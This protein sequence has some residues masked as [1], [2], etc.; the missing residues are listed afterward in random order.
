VK[1]CF[2]C[3]ASLDIEFV[4]RREECPQCGADARVCLNCDF[5]EEGRGNSCREP[6]AEQVKEKDRS[7]FCGYFR[8]KETAAE[9]KSGREDADRLWQELFKKG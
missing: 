5:Y 8:F 4:G 3:R 9:K 2:K 1:T 6:Q 7:N